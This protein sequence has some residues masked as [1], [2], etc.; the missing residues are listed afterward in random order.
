MASVS[1]EHVHG[2]HPFK[3]GRK[4][5]HYFVDV[6]ER[7]LADFEMQNSLYRAENYDHLLF[8]L[9]TQMLSRTIDG[10]DDLAESQ[11]FIPSFDT[12]LALFTLMTASDHYKGS[13]L[14]RNEPYCI[15]RV[16][17]SKR[18]TK[19]LNSYL[20]LLRVFDTNSY[21]TYELELL[22]C[23]MFLAIDAITPRFKYLS[24]YKVVQKDKSNGNVIYKSGAMPESKEKSGIM[25]PYRSFISCLESK[26]PIFGNVPINFKLSQRGGLGNAILW[27]LANSNQ[28][29]DT[30]FYDAYIIWIPFFNIYLE[31]LEMR[32]EY[33]LQNE[34]I[35][36]IS[37][38]LMVEKLIESPLASFFTFVDS[39][40]FNTA[41]CEYLF[42]NCD[43]TLINSDAPL[44]IQPV[45]RGEDQ[46]D[47]EFYQRTKFTHQFKSA[48]SMKLRRRFLSLCYRLLSNVPSG[49]HL[50]KPRIHSKK[51]T[52]EIAR[53]LNTFQDISE[54]ESFF[55]N[56]QL[57]RYMREIAEKTLNELI[58]QD[59]RVFGIDKLSIVK[60]RSDIRMFLTQILYLF[61]KGIMTP[62]VKVQAGRVIDK[63]GHIR[64]EILRLKKMDICVI[65][66]LF[67]IFSNY[68][69]EEK[70]TNS[71]LVNDLLSM[72]HNID[73][74]RKN[75]HSDFSQISNYVAAIC[76]K[77]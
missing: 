19:V 50:P 42:I 48:I 45:Y 8:F 71:L 61:K 23:Q 47:K 46:I 41:F 74:K 60:K 18:A 32:Q 70:S 31:I 11:L 16:S 29:D 69:M 58:K 59:R 4:L 67:T 22:R 57:D 2:Y 63:E 24:G 36:N 54:F 3:D 62:D 14:N 33:F 52:L 77:R 35:K 38:N 26:H 65:T 17:V 20:H 5:P 68:S 43:Y 21:G 9:E 10:D 44:T 1:I 53:I 27:A 72:S 34:V 28:K 25:N 73:E 55:V 56:P 76:T 75:I 37:K 39:V 12:I 6:R 51:L 7:Q 40:N 15:N 49:M 64:S 30:L 13:L 66:L